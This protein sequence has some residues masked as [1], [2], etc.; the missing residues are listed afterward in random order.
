MVPA[1]ALIPAPIAY[2]KVV[3]VKNIVVDL[4]LGA[5]DP[6]LRV[7][8]RIVSLHPWGQPVWH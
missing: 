2:I 1:A 6:S 8:T 7:G 3:V 5:I 4:L